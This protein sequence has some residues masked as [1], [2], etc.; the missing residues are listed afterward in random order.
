MNAPDNRPEDFAAAL[1][2]DVQVSY[3]TEKYLLY[4][5]HIDGSTA[6]CHNLWCSQLPPTVAPRVAHAIR[7]RLQV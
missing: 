5:Y 2:A 7:E 4:R 6:P 1:C 3:G